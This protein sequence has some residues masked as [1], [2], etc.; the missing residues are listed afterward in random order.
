MRQ[1]LNYFELAGAYSQG[2]GN[3]GNFEADASVPVNN[4]PVTLDSFL[5]D[6]DPPTSYGAAQ[7]LFSRMLENSAPHM[8]AQELAS[9]A[10]YTTQDAEPFGGIEMSSYGA[11]HNP[12]G[13]S[14]AED[15]SA[16]GGS[17]F[18]AA[19]TGLEAFEYGEYGQLG[20]EENEQVDYLAG[21]DISPYID[22]DEI[23][24][25]GDPSSSR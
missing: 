24:G 7:G 8:A 14:I 18:Q 2:T 22:F 16:F 3:S 17:A 6:N 15:Y 4:H 20:D 5:I 21:L 25:L 13:F 9:S 23:V 1:D 19:G 11:E 12:G 10:S